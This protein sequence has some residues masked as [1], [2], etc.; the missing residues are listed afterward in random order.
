MA[1]LVPGSN[2]WKKVTADRLSL[3]QDAGPTFAAMASVMEA[4][5]KTIFIVGWD[6]DSRTVLRPDENDPHRRTLL[7]LLCR[8]LEQRP[9]LHIFVLIWDFSVIYSF[10]R[11]P[12]PRHQFGRAHPRLHFS[13]DANHGS[14]GSHHQ[15]LVVVDD[16]VAFVGGI[17]LTLHRWDTP[18]HLPV[19][20][21]RSEASGNL[22]GPFHDVH[23]VV[24]GPAAV[25]L[26]E[27]ARNRWQR[28]RRRPTPPPPA[29]QEPALGQDPAAAAT[30]T[31]GARA[32]AWP[33]DLAVDATKIEVGLAR[34][35][36]FPGQPAIKE[37]EALTL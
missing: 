11:E 3:L 6:L 25:A 23:A 22:Y 30:S 31:S 29:N 36:A 28:D 1:F 18:E 17:D 4:A 7:P 21:R 13:L 26:G 27:L 33:A 5:R 16:Q 20:H 9:E 14:G 15:K 2:C 10:E 37:V 35:L 34:T 12:R 24:S 32:S 19:N 8:C